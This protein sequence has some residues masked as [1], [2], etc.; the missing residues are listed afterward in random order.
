MESFNDFMQLKLNERV[1]NSS[2]RQL[3]L[4][5]KLIDFSSNDYLGIANERNSGSTGSRLISGNSNEV[6]AL[7]HFFS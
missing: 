5:E 6:E 4:T 7:E 1:S 3:R 2:K